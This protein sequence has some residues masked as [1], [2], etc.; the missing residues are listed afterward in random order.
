MYPALG[1]VGWCSRGTLDLP[2]LSLIAALGALYPSLLALTLNCWSA[3]VTFRADHAVT[4]GRSLDRALGALYALF[5]ATG[6][7]RAIGLVGGTLS[8]C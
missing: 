6:T 1:L 8:A 7:L 3:D 5:V 4:M 2:A